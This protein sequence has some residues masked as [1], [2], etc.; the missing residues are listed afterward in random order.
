MSEIIKT[1]LTN[2]HFDNILAGSLKSKKLLIDQ[3][4]Y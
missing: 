3:E 1:K 4:Y 2:K